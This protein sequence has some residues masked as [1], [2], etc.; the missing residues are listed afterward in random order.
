MNISR[1]ARMHSDKEPASAQSPAEKDE[2][3]KLMVI[4]NAALKVA[5][6]LACLYFFVVALNL[7]STSFPLIG[8]I[9]KASKKI[10][11]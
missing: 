2:K 7:M 9:F 4:A 8:G 11:S 3:S 10:N 1:N 5:G 6:L